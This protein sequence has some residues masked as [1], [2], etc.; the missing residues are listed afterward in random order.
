MAL[1]LL[2]GLF[3]ACIASRSLERAAGRR[4]T[5]VAILFGFAVLLVVLNIAA[6]G[7]IAARGMAFFYLLKAA[8]LLTALF[9]VAGIL[10][11]LQRALRNGRAIKI[12]GA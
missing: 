2:A 6:A 8:L 11:G 12:H 10:F 9:A 1:S 5:T 3:S 7:F 4:D